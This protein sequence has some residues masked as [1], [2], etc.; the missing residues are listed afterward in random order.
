MGMFLTET[1]R[2]W[3]NFLKEAAK[4]KPPAKGLRPKD[5]CRAVLYDVVTGDKFEIAILTVIICN[6]VMMMIQHYGQSAQV[7]SIL[8]IL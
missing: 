8:H 5:R 3:V 4:K 2:K 6:M 1:Q 7:S